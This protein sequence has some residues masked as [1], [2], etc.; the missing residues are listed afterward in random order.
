MPQRH[1]GEAQLKIHSFLALDL[2]EWSI[3]HTGCFISGEGT[4]HTHWLGGWVNPKALVDICFGEERN[5]N[6]VTLQ[7]LGTPDRW[8]ELPLRWSRI[9]MY[10]YVPADHGC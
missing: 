7:G 8:A 1:I 10:N 4:L 6:L 9:Y 2:V 5:E 3:L